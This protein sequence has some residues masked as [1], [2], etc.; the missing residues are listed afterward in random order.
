MP[1]LIRR[2]HLFIEPDGALGGFAHFL[3]VGPGHQRRGQTER[4]SPFD[5]TDQ[6]RARDDIAPL[7]RPAHLQDAA[8]AAVQLQVVVG[9]Q[10]HIV[11]LD[12][13][14]RLLPVEPRLDALKGQQ[15]IDREMLA[16]IA[17]EIDVMQ[18]IQP[19]S[20]VDERRVGRPVAI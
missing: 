11:E 12:E 8:I 7:I 1:E 3:T 17:Q 5:P 15:P 18:L 19:L 10:Q 13:A 2:H 20:I 16:D 9:L 14:Q 6:I 4:I